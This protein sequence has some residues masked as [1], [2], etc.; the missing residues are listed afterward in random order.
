M[1]ILA[2]YRVNPEFPPQLAA[3]RAMTTE[4]TECLNDL[5]LPINEPLESA[6]TFSEPSHSLIDWFIGNPP[7]LILWAIC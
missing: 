1:K 2:C 7:P 4:L 5:N 6:S 3:G